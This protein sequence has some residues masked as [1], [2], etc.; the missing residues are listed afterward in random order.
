M[1]CPVCTDANDDFC[2][3]VTEPLLA[4]RLR[5]RVV[6]DEHADAARVP[7]RRVAERDAV[8][9]RHRS[10]PED[11]ARRRVA[12]TGDGDPDAEDSSRVE[13]G[14]HLRQRV[15][16]RADDAS[17]VVRRVERDDALLELLAARV[18]ERGVDAGP[19]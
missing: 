6:V 4:E 9:R 13:R 1:P 7:R 11:V 2:A 12:H 15:A 19:A 5:P 10:G 14:Q 17:L 8:Q 3:S 18:D 16:E